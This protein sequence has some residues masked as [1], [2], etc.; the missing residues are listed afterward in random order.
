MS[1]DRTDQ[2]EA[3]VRDNMDDIIHDHVNYDRPVKIAIKTKELRVLECGTDDG[4]AYGTYEIVVN[5]GQIL[6]RLEA[7]GTYEGFI[8]KWDYAGDTHYTQT[9][10]FDGLE[11]YEHHVI[12]VIEDGEREID[13]TVEQEIDSG[14]EN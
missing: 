2:L 9:V 5:G 3:M 12:K 13:K 1:G 10:A 7:N 11:D 14:K 4:C 6:I 8:D